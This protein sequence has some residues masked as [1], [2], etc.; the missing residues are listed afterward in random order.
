MRSS[1]RDVT[2]KHAEKQLRQQNGRKC[3]K[4]E[5]KNDNFTVK[6]SGFF[7][8]ENPVIYSYLYSNDFSLQTF[9]FIFITLKQNLEYN[10]ICC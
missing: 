7:H 5:N 6:L 9:F 4:S 1:Q 10:D 3:N 2:V 8:S